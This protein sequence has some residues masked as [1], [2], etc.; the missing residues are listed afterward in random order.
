MVNACYYNY[1]QQ[2]PGQDIG[3][4]DERLNVHFPI[5]RVLKEFVHQHHSRDLEDKLI[6]AQVASHQWALSVIERDLAKD[7]RLAAKYDIFGDS[8]TLTDRE[9]LDVIRSHNR[10][11]AW[12]A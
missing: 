10:R 2:R 6:M 12:W 8:V 4:V 11:Q 3:V 7:Y 9:I 5:F 1:R